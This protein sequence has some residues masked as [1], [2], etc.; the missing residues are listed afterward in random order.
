MST[1]ITTNPY[2]FTVEDDMSI[3]AVFEDDAGKIMAVAAGGN[4]QSGYNGSASMSISGVGSVSFHYNGA[5]MSKSSDSLTGKTISNGDVIYFNATGMAT[6]YFQIG[7]KI[8]FTIREGS[9]S[10]TIVKQYIAD[11]YDNYSSFT[12]SGT[13]GKKYYLG[14]YTTT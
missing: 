10:G 6:A 1:I 13:A 5:S 3:K 4:V 14:C 12:F 8:N 7:G 9:A 11:R 2:T